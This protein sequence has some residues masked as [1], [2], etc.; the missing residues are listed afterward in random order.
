MASSLSNLVSNLS[1]GIYR[2]KCKYRVKCGNCR[3]EYKYCD[4]F[5]KCTNFKDDFIEYKCLWC[6]KKYQYKFDEKLKEQFFITRK[7]SNHGNNKYILLLRKDICPYE[8]IR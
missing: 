3:V 7:F 8:Y 6:I 4:W 2:M 1:E 5:L